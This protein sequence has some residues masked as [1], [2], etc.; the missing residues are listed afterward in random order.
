MISWLL[1]HS[2]RNRP[3]A[4]ELRQDTFYQR[5]LQCEVPNF[6]SSISRQQSQTMVNGQEQAPVCH[7][8][9]RVPSSSPFRRTFS[10]SAIQS[11]KTSECG[12]SECVLK[13]LAQ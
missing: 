10:S 7:Q 6:F 8:R 11:H 12:D 9:A 5:L 13:I 4:S 2:P 3:R 1:S